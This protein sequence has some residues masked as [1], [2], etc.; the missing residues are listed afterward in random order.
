MTGESGRFYSLLSDL[1]LSLNARFDQAYTTALY[2]DPV[3]SLVQN[4]RPQ[5]T[6]ITSLGLKLGK[7]T[8]APTSF[9]FAIAVARPSPSPIN[10][11]CAAQ[12]ES[13]QPTKGSCV[14]PLCL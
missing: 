12:V 4:M 7:T 11:A 1:R 14:S 8:T 5:G 2:I 13:G 10:A 6:W 3:T 9:A